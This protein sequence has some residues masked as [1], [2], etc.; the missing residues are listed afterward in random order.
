MLRA[1]RV[2]WR[3]GMHTRIRHRN[4][5]SRNGQV[6][7]GSAW[8]ALLRHGLWEKGLGVGVGAWLGPVLGRAGVGGTLFLEG[9]LESG[10]SME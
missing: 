10:E 6:R 4:L 1:L 2:V 8:E 5:G 3:V 7:L 9:A